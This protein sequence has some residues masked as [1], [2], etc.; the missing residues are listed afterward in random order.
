[1]LISVTGGWTKDKGRNEFDL[2]VKAVGADANEVEHLKS[3]LDDDW[4]VE[5]VSFDAG[6]LTLD[7]KATRKVTLEAAAAAKKAE[8][9]AAAAKAAEDAKAAQAVAAE[10]AA[11]DARVAGIAAAA[12]K[13]AVSAIL[14][15]EAAK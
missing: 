3:L 2:S 8:E 10:Q 12:S 9:E 1:M 11:K 7:V 4:T 6:Q 14:E 13:A 5:G 15:A